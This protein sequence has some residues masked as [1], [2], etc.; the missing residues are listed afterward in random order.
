MSTQDETAATSSAWTVEERAS[1]AAD[2][3]KV[4]EHM[5][6][7][8]LFMLIREKERLIR[9]L[10]ADQT[11]LGDE[12]TTAAYAERIRVMVADLTELHEVKVEAYKAHL[13]ELDEIEL[14]EHLM[15][16]I[17]EDGLHRGEL[18]TLLDVSA[19]EGEVDEAT[20]DTRR[21]MIH[22]RRDSSLFCFFEVTHIVAE[23]K[24]RHIE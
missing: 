2:I 14:I 5:P 20:Q 12:A 3:R 6:R 4:Y 8:A 18:E 21:M 23:L 17:K 9:E 1:F 16:A 10:E 13:T 22:F 11:V 7:V 24:R 19:T 15:A